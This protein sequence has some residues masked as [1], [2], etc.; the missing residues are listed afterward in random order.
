[1]S[2]FGLKAVF[3]YAMRGTDQGNTPEHSCI[4]NGEYNGRIVVK[5]FGDMGHFP[6]SLGKYPDDIVVKNKDHQTAKKE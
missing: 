2:Q 5:C 6:L 3:S 4:L 1:M